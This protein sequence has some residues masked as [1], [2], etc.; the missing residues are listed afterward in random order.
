MKEIQGFGQGLGKTARGSACR[1]LAAFL[2]LALMVPLLSACSKKEEETPTGIANYGNQGADFARKLASSF[3]QRF[4]YS[5]QEAAAADLIVDE[6]KKLG[7]EAGKQTFSVQ[8]Q[9]G[10]VKQSAN[11]IARLSGQ[12]FQAVSKQGSS[13]DTAPSSVRDDLIMIIGA[14]YDTP[15]VEVPA[16]DDPEAPAPPDGIHNNA[17]GVAALLTA[18]RIMRQE[19]PGYD[20]IFVFFGAGT[21]QFAG[22]S[23]FLSSLSADE[24]ARVDVMVNIGPIYAGDKIYAHAG[25]N[26][27][28][29]DQ[30][31]DYAKRRKLYQATD[32]FFE[33]QLNTR[34][35]YAVFTNQASFPVTLESGQQAVFREWTSLESDHT[36]F[37]KAGIPV[38]FMESGDYR[39]SKIEDVGI[40]SRNPFFKDTGGQ[41][42]GTRFDQTEILE[43]L[44]RQMDEQTA[45]QTIPKIES[46]EEEEE[47]ET[48]EDASQ[49]LVPRLVLRINNTA[50]LLVQLARK[51]PLNFEF[52]S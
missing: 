23:H 11:V 47:G 1:L 7:Y 38:V 4:P 9:E 18:A 41:I 30:F 45:G 3:P 10:G 26:S 19:T 29:E 25:Q 5:S 40:E 20:V 14:H 24:R 16:D 22:A 27:V 35:R 51:G 33:Y 17:A 49:G 6:L 31:K 37:D 36:P 34:N 2:I 39:I 15:L 12:G 13:E 46:D 52:R 50:F 42:S 21:D 43:E 44:F 32:I 48:P 28:L 8:D